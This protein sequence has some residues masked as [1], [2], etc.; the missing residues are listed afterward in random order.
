MTAGESHVEGAGDQWDMA[1]E[2]NAI[3]M[4]LVVMWVKRVGS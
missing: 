4:H 1:P 2:L 3:F